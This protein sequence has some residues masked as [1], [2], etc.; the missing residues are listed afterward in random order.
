MTTVCPFDSGVSPCAS[1]HKLIIYK[2]Y[3]DKGAIR[4]AFLYAILRTR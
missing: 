1:Q 4:G 2:I 3:N